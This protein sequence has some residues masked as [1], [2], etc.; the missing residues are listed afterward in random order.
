MN[1]FIIDTGAKER[2]GLLAEFSSTTYAPLPTFT[3]IETVSRGFRLVQSGVTPDI[4]P[5]DEID[6]STIGLE[7]G[8]SNAD[9]APTAG[10]WSL[11]FNGDSTGLTAL[12]Y[13]ITASALQTALNANPAIAA[14]GGVTVSQSGRNYTV[15]FNT[16][17]NQPLFAATATTL[18]PPSNVYVQVYQNGSSTVREIQ[19]LRVEQRPLAYQN[20]WTVTTAGAIA[21]SSVVSG[22]AAIAAV[23]QVSITGDPYGGSWSLTWPR[24][25]VCSFSF[26]ANTAAKQKFT[27]IPLANTSHAL[28]NTF[29]DC[30]DDA[31]TVRVWFDSSSTG[32][33][34]PTPTGGRLIEVNI[35][36][37]DT[38][39]AVATAI[40]STLDGD[41][42]F[43]A[44]IL[45]GITITVEAA[46]A[47]TRTS[48]PVDGTTATG[49]TF[50]TVTQGTAGVLSGAVML[51]YDQN[52]SVGV[53]LN[54]GSLATPTEAASARRQIPV[55]IA[56][57][58]SANTVATA[59]QT[60]IDADA[61]FSATV[62]GNL[63]TITDAQGGARATQASV[64][65]GEDYIGAATVT[66]GDSLTVTVPWDVTSD[67]LEDLLNNEWLVTL[68][69]TST[70]S[71]YTFTGTSNGARSTFTVS[72]NTLVWAKYYAG[73]LSLNTFGMQEAFN[74]TTADSISAVFEARMTPS[75][76]SPQTILRLFVTVFRSVLD[77][78]LTASTPAV[79]SAVTL[80]GDITG[81][82]TSSIATTAATA[83]ITGKT[84][85][86]SPDGAADYVLTYDA[87]ANALKKVL[88]DDLP[89]GGTGDVDGPAGATDNA[90][91]LFDGTTGKLLKNGTVLS[92][93]GTV[94]PTAASAGVTLRDSSATYNLKL[95]NTDTPTADRTLQISLNDGT[96]QLYLGASLTVPAAP[97]ADRLFFWDHSSLA[98]AWL[99]LGTNL[100]ITGT[101]L[102][103][104]GGVSDGDYGDIVVS[105]SGTVWTIDD[106]VIFPQMFADATWGDLSVSSGLVTIDAGAVTFAQ[107][108]DISTS[109]GQG[110]LLGQTP[111][112]AGAMV[113]IA[114]GAGFSFSGATI[115][116]DIISQCSNVDNAML[117]ANAPGGGG[118]GLQNS[119]LILSDETAYSSQYY[120]AITAAGAQTNN[121]IAFAPKGTGAFI[122][123]PAPNGGATTGGNNRG[124]Y[125]ID[126]QLE[127]SSATQVAS[128]SAAITVG[129]RCTASG[130]GALAMGYASSAG[131]SY[132]ISIGN[133]CSSNALDGSVAVGNGCSASGY[134]AVAVGASCTASNTATV[135]V[136][137]N[138]TASANTSF[139]IGNGSTATATATGAMGSAAAS[140][141]QGMI[142]FAAGAFSAG[143]DAQ[144]M[145][146]VQR[147]Q[148]TSTTPTLLRSDGSSVNFTIPSN[149]A[150]TGYI[151]VIAKQ[152][153]SANVCSYA[154]TFTAVNN[155][156]TSTL[157]QSSVTVL[158]E[159]NAAADCTIAVDDATDSIQ[160]T[161][162]APDANTWRVVATGYCTEVA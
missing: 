117:R 116:N 20:T 85:D 162:T 77:S 100:S 7:V 19:S 130:T 113:E 2:N 82:G 32:T 35:T 88:L 84:A 139:A 46:S 103:A 69:R 80:T 39:A 48:G 111:G 79:P 30:Q 3:S 142:S 106:A 93:S 64:A 91:A 66:P 141:R 12:A 158:Y 114:I 73:D 8:I 94:T 129:S 65:V 6:M 122:L 11:S 44:S 13:N 128:G 161:W 135:S 17:G 53:W 51:I 33:A 38:A 92:I 90:F 31:G 72:A 98:T 26:S 45:T 68:N 18:I 118:A 59:V 112:G 5:W 140:S 21:A 143:G 109:G 27:V 150:I 99:T 54:T 37:G 151:E 9:L 62:S 146:Y 119:A 22:T 4:R 75:G 157:P 71:I 154:I 43:V 159:S 126:L 105:S 86:A 50:S 121:H 56:A 96:R 63:V 156:G 152:A 10:T 115:I 28:N 41:S 67:V 134:H 108:Q 23:Q 25:E 24:P 138:C 70:T 136:G 153:S 97:G 133:G 40:Q 132:A 123:G 127:R 55:T 89:G 102:N 61:E 95:E 74:A 14:A 137:L 160:I 16:A 60:A 52:G 120:I 131:T 29:F 155:G 149:K 15:I 148:T 1:P 58:D 57:G 147:I 49:F 47:G 107:F 81:T 110:T 83:L 101:T 124:T 78:Q 125:A 87:S 76:G 104:A 42:A 34:P 36:N 145:F 144:A